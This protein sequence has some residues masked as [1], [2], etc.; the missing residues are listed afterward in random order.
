MSFTR[1]SIR[2]DFFRDRPLELLSS[3]ELRATAFLYETGIAG[4]RIENSRSSMVVLPYMGKQVWF[5][6]FDGRRLSQKSMFDMPQDTTKFGDNYGG[7]LYHCGLNNVNGPADGEADYPMHD[8]LPFARY[9]DAYVGVGEN[10]RGRY[11]AVGGTFVYR[12][13]QELHWAYIPELRLYEGS[14]AVEM[15]ATV[16]NRRTHPLEYVWL[17]H[18]NWLGVDGSDFVYSCPV[19]EDHVQVVPTELGDDSPR[20]VAIRE[21]SNRLVA[22]PT[23][24]DTLDSS[25]QVYDP[26]L[27][28]NYRYV[29]D[30]KG[31]A[32]AMQVMPDGDACYVAWDTAKAPYALR[33]FCR[34]GDEDGVGIALPSTGTCHSTAYQ[35]AHGHFNTLEP[36]GT[37]TLH[38]WFGYLDADGAAAMQADI[39]KTLA[40]H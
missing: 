37:D 12:N 9:R 24:A 30:E 35:R 6:D 20:A 7:F 1:V 32:R 21:Y 26:E 28:I 33:W 18:M 13:S 29:A 19:D 10:E 14:T 11:L 4:L 17:C 25:T 40:E 15:V 3:G 39:E 8:V 2:P 31:W 38:W 23:I 16:E 36:G 5:V 27:C 22:D 34:T